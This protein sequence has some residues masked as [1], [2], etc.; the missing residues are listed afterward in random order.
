MITLQDGPAHDVKLFLER[1][2]FLL[3]VVLSNQ[4]EWDALD[5]TTDGPS[6]DEHVF[7][8]WIRPAPVGRAHYDGTRNGKRA[9]WFSMMATYDY[10]P[11]QPTDA[12]MRTTEAWDKWCEA[13][14]AV[15]PF[16]TR[17]EAWQKASFCSQ[18]QE[19]GQ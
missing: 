19:Q 10:C 1:A 15:K 8:Y 7:V 11:Y 3:R 13:T 5:Q 12:E 16:A 18:N 2:P 9:G 4:G 17:F 6:D 14:K